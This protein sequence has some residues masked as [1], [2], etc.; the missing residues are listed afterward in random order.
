MSNKSMLLKGLMLPLSLIATCNSIAQESDLIDLNHTIETANAKWD[1]KKY[2]EH[3]KRYT[4]QKSA[5]AKGLNVGGFTTTSL[6]YPIWFELG[7]KSF[8]YFV[9]VS[10][11]EFESF[12]TIINTDSTCTEV[13]SFGVPSVHCTFLLK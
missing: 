7:D 5:V 13:E 6:N 1:N 11:N 4:T 12:V 10:M 9:G 8:A 2:I 3:A